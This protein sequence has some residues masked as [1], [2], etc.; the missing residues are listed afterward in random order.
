MSTHKYIPPTTVDIGEG[1]TF[2]VAELIGYWIANAG[3]YNSN[4]PGL[5]SGNALTDALTEADGGWIKVDARDHE[6]LVS[7]A[8]NPQ[9]I[10][11]APAYP[12]RPARMCLPLIEAIR[13]ANSTAPKLELLA[14]AA[15]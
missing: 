2:S 1:R 8:E 4:G 14:E 7:V 11:P 3:V 6:I 15:E 12:L 10:A 9:P 5:R 13:D